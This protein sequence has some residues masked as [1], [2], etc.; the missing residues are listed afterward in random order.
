MEKVKTFIALVV[1]IINLAVISGA[2]YKAHEFSLL[3][4]EVENLKEATA[5]LQ[6]DVAEIKTTNQTQMKYI[7][8]IL[9][10]T[11][12]KIKSLD[13]AQNQIVEALANQVE[14]NK[15]LLSR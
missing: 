1:I 7:T 4:A 13:E 10:K 14:I 15:I 6:K 11:L 9:D 3:T 8:E 12:Q 2:I 5:Q